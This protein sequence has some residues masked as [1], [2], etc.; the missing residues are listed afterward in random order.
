[1]KT[2]ARS[3]PAVWPYAVFAALLALLA[4]TAWTAHFLTGPAG[5][6]AALFFAVA[7]TTLVFAYFMRLRHQS[8]IVR[9]AAGAGFAWLALLGFF[10]AVDYLTR[11]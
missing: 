4:L 2:A 1:M 11:T 7:K 5:L 9:L 10:V 3:G 6:A 8:G